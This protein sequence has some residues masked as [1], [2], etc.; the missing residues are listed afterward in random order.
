MEEHALAPPHT[1]TSIQS[2]TLDLPPSCIEF[3]PAHPDYLVIGTYNLEKNEPQSD[4]TPPAEIDGVE[5]RAAPRSQE[6]NGSL[7]VYRLQDRIL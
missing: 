2:L 1:I 4:S 7:L 6:R 3:C 5:E